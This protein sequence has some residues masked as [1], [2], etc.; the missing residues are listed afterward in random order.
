V[1]RVVYSLLWIFSAWGTWAYFQGQQ[2]PVTTKSIITHGGDEY[3][4]KRTVYQY[5]DDKWYWRELCAVALFFVLAIP[6][7]VVWFEGF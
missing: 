3:V 7:V 6:M 2:V 1:F 4:L 5:P